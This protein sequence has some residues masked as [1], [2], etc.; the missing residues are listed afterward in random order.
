MRDVVALLLVLTLLGQSGVAWAQAA[1]P[2]RGTQTVLYGA[3]S[4]LGTVV[5]TPLKGLLCVM[6]GAASGLQFLVSGARAT[7]AV[8]TA[9]CAGT[10]VITPDVLKGKQP[11]TF[12]AEIR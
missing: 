1:S 6:G 3:G 2:E 10:W 11:L 12:V 8:A 5:Y 9:S 4:V 7:R